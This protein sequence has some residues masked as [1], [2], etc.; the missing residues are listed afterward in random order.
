LLLNAKRRFFDP[1]LSLLFPGFYLTISHASQFRSSR[2]CRV[3]S[4]VEPEWRRQ[5]RCEFARDAERVCLRGDLLIG[6]PGRSLG[7]PDGTPLDL[8]SVEIESG[9]KLALERSFALR[10]DTAHL[11]LGKPFPLADNSQ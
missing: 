4:M 10:S 8:I 1:G 11:I 2:A 5:G 3:L 6:F 7:V 9:G